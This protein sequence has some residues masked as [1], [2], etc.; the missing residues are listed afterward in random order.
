[1]FDTRIVIVKAVKK[2][3]RCGV[4]KGF[5]G[6]SCRS[7]SGCGESVEKVWD[8]AVSSVLVACAVED[9]AQISDEIKAVFIFKHGSAV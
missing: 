8:N 9:V 1:M 3:C 2:Q 6:I 7:D 5:W 4:G